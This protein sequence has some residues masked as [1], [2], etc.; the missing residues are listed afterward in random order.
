M[1]VLKQKWDVIMTLK[2]SNEEETMSWTA[3]CGMLCFYRKRMCHRAPQ[4]IKIIE[5]FE[6]WP[7]WKSANSCSS[8]SLDTRRFENLITKV[9]NMSTE[10][11]NFWMIKLVRV[12]DKDGDH[13]PGNA[14]Y[15]IVCSIKRYLK[16]NGRAEYNMLDVKNYRYVV[17]DWCM[18]T[19]QYD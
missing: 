3:K 7:P 1:Q 15:Q 2:N 5:Q 12:C 13:Y 6:E 10:I 19:E 18:F 8:F 14:L 17:L 11:L 16:E 4:D 9:L